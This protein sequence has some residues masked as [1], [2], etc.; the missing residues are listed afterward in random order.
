MDPTLP[1]AVGLDVG[2]TKIAAGVVDTHGQVRVFDRFPTPTVPAEIGPAMVA[3][4]RAVARQPEG[5]LDIPIGCGFPSMITRDGLARYGPNIAVTEYP[6]KQVLQLGLGRR[7]IVVDNDANAA[8]W[9][10]W[11]IGAGRNARSDM[12]MFT[13]GTG[14][15]GGLILNGT[16]VR[17]AHGFAGELGHMII[18][19]DG[20]SGPSRIPGEVEGYCSGEAQRRIA[21]EMHA[22]GEFDGTPLAGPQPPSPAA[23]SVAALDGVAAARQVQ[24]IVGRSLGIACASLVNA[25]DVELIVIG[26]GAASAGELIL[27]PARAA[28]DAHVLGP[29]HRPEVPIVAAALGPDAGV[30]GA[31][32]LAL[33]VDGRTLQR[34]R[35]W[36]LRRRRGALAR[37]QRRRRRT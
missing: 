1:I 28:Y 24:A 35:P 6:L 20:A 10:E 11:A 34:V 36:G 14:V 16:L 31:A 15:G 26:G 25:L 27:T 13:L 7:D 21:A 4:A 5:P 12:A 37:A 32:L 9:A 8:I 22:R 3:A 29:G 18:D 30:V 33:G 17:G 2:G 23:V 19:L